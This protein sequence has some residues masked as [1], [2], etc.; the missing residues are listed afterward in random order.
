M[1]RRLVCLM[2]AV[3]LLC[4]VASSAMAEDKGVTKI[5]FNGGA[6]YD[7]K[8]PVGFQPLV[9]VIKREYPAATF[10]V[11]AK[12]SFFGLTVVRQQELLVGISVKGADGELATITWVSDCSVNSQYQVKSLQQVVSKEVIRPALVALTQVR[13]PHLQ[14]AVQSYRHDK[15]GSAEVVLKNDKKQS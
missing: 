9:D 6:V 5:S 4:C 7:S 10:A 12:E 14:G 3:A 1:I 13:H 15:D 8:V 2:V 11:R